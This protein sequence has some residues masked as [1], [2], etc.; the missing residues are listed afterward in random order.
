MKGD[1]SHIDWSEASAAL[2]ASFA[3]GVIRLAIAV[4]KAR[5]VRIVD[6]II[7]PGL[8]VIGGMTVWFLVEDTNASDSMQAALTSLGAFGG[9]KT[10]AMLERRYLKTESDSLPPK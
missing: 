8:A 5:Q 1:W 6:I 4:R 7:E 9:G 2:L 10:L 3:V